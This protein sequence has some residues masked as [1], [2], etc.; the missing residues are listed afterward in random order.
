MFIN[1]FLAANKSCFIY[2]VLTL[3]T[4]SKV[5]SPAT[6]LAIRAEFQ[7]HPYKSV[8]DSFLF[9]VDID[10]VACID[11]HLEPKLWPHSYVKVKAIPC[12]VLK[13]FHRRE[14]SPY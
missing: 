5:F 2:W 7:R 6:L 13:T 1:F 9:C 10:K 12:A 3:N 14:L 11:G 8:V 4:L